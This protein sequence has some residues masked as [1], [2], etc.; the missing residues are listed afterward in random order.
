[1]DLPRAAGIG[2]G[3]AS[4]LLGLYGLLHT[5]PLPLSA[6]LGA[7]APVDRNHDGRISATEWAQ[8]GKPAAAMAALDKNHN[9]FVEPA[10]A[11]SRQPARG[12]H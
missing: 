5:K 8:A 12:G 6:R 2:L 3:L 10:E 4:T 7:L 11:R 1:M 9:G